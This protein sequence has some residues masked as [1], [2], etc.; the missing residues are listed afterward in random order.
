MKL[1]HLMFNILFTKFKQCILIK[2]ARAK[3][4]HLINTKTLIFFLMKVHL[5]NSNKIKI[6]S[7]FV[8]AYYKRVW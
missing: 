2:L 7:T 3:D 4:F 6:N 8:F 1:L 5:L